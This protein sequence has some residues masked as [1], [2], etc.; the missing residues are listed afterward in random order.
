MQEHSEGFVCCL[1]QKAQVSLP[2]PFS[3][4]NSRLIFFSQNKNKKNVL[5]HQKQM[6]GKSSFAPPTISASLKRGNELR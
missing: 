3:S 4:L 6:P 5:S 1:Y 2:P